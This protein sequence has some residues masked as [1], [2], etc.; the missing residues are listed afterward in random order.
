[1]EDVLHAAWITSYMTMLDLHSG[2]FQGESPDERPIDDASRLLSP[3]ELNYTTTERDSLALVWVAYNFQIQYTPEKVY[4][5]SDALS[6]PA[7]CE[8]NP[9][10]CEVCLVAVSIPHRTPD[11]VRINQLKDPELKSIG[12]LG[13]T[14]DPL[15]EKRR[16]ERGYLV[17]YGVLYRC[18]P[19]SEDADT[20]CLVVLKHEREMMY[21]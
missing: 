1:M 6:R 20:A 17:S 7:C 13:A 14:D 18:A 21:L 8:V 16:S 4:V 12:D 9:D 3:A 2:Y 5:I 15:R 19:E 10:F 11:N